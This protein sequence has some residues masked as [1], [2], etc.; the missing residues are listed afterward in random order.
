MHFP[1]FLNEFLTR[2]RILPP[3][4]SLDGENWNF[5]KNY[6]TRI[7]WGGMGSLLIFELQKKQTLKKKKNKNTHVIYNSLILFWFKKKL[8]G[9]SQFSGSLLESYIVKIKTN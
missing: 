4:L 3:E 7:R 5:F 6:F 9:N 1:N 8:S 2:F